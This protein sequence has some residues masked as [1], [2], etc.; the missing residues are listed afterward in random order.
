MPA[1]KTNES[2]YYPY[3]GVLLKQI[4]LYNDAFVN[5]GERNLAELMPHGTLLAVKNI[6]PFTKFASSEISISWTLTV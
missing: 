5:L 1:Q 3:N 2:Y 6:L 4:G